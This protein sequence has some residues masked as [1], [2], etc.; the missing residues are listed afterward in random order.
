MQLGLLKD[1]S[2]KNG[3][4]LVGVDIGTTKICAV[5]GEVSGQ[6]STF[7]VIGVGTVPSRG[8]KKGV[9]TNI[10]KTVKSIRKAVSEAERMAGVD[11]RAAQIGITGAHIRCLSSN[12]VIAVQEKEIGR[13]DVDSVIEAAKAVAIPFDREIL[14]VIPLGFSVNGENGIT[15][16]CGME[17][18]RLETN[19]Q[20]ITAA[21]TSVHNLTSSCRKAGLELLDVVFQPLASANAVLTQDEKDLGVVLI[22]IGGGTTDIALFRNGT[23]C[24]SSV[25]PI[26]GNNFTNDIAI[27]LRLPTQEAENIKKKFGCSMISLVKEEEEIEVSCSDTSVNKK[28]PRRYLVEILQPRAEELFTLIREDLMNSGFHENMNSGVV[29]TGGAV[30]MQGMDVMAESILELPIRIGIP[31]GVESVTDNIK[32]PAYAT[33]VGLMLHGVK[34][35]LLEQEYKEK[36][37]IGAG[38]RVRRWFGQMFG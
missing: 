21:A 4:L 29:L 32:S 34:E 5:V 38:T 30:L 33:A 26:G 27:G 16:P 11:I 22:D 17:G 10:E 8:I 13:R 20:I 2:M 7:N 18:I 24:H 15:D 6:G 3:R 37:V 14:H 12:G 25:L 1:T 19:V 31:E 28:I 23:L 9:V 35:V 36:A